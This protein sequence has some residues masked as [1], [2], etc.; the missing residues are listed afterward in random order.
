MALI[1]L[2]LIGLGWFLIDQALDV[3]MMGIKMVIRY[4]KG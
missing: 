1:G 3:M 4:L 2:I